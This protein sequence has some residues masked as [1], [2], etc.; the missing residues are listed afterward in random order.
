M[1]FGVAVTL[2][3]TSLVLF[4]SKDDAPAAATASEVVTTKAKDARATKSFSITAA[5]IITPH[6]AGA[7]ALISF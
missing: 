7:G 2:G 1:S 4:L 5:P 6:S 3:V